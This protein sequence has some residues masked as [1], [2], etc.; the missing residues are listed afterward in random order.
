MPSK[1][2]KKYE[3][4]HVAMKEAQMQQEDPVERYEV[5]DCV[6]LLIFNPMLLVNYCC[7][8]SKYTNFVL[9]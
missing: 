7:V 9:E 6:E 4:E 5:S 8:H 1:K 3:K 2:L